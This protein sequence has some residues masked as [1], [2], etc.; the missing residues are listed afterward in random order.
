MSTESA[1]PPRPLP[2]VRLAVYV[3]I[4]TG[5]G[6]V[7]AYDAYYAASSTTT[8]ATVRSVGAVRVG[9]RGGASYVADYEY[10]DAQGVRHA[11]RA[12][13]VPPV[14]RAGDQVEVQYLRHMPSS[15]RLAP[16]PVRGLSYGAVALLA[17]GVFAAEVV[18][19][20]GLGGRRQ[21]EAGPD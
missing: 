5:C 9:A 6:A 20:R 1:E 13:G 14:T 15:S 3:L 18:V 19:R 16:S 12:E 10:L 7:A 17:A 2:L 4:F 8:L 21:G 11:G